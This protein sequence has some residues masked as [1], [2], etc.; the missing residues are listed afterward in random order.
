MVL[1][2]VASLSRKR[3]APVSSIP[4]KRVATAPTCQQPAL[5]ITVC[6]LCPQLHVVRLE[7]EP[8]PLPAGKK[9][10]GGA[11]APG[12]GADGGLAVGLFR[13]LQSSLAAAA[14]RPAEAPAW[15][16]SELVFF[17]QVQP[18]RTR[19]RARPRSRRGGVIF[20]VPGVV[21]TCFFLHPAKSKNPQRVPPMIECFNL[22]ARC[23]VW[24]TR[25]QPTRILLGGAAALASAASMVLPP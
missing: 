4:R 11:H 25:P 23:C 22:P 21:R 8:G 18:A 24:C 16:H 15:A 2:P 1:P 13:A 3:V 19:I 17:T 5:A 6:T 14:A 9:M 12:S 20:Q 7:P 10:A